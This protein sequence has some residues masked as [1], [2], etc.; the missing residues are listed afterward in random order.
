ML[1]SQ[2]KSQKQACEKWALKLEPLIINRVRSENFWTG[3]ISKNT[4]TDET[5]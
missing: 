5:I 4:L 1:Y 2:V 3:E